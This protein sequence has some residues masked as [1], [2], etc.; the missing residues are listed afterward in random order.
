VTGTSL[1]IDGGYIATAEWDAAVAPV[2][3]T[4]NVGETA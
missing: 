2:A 4:S 3:E 1:V